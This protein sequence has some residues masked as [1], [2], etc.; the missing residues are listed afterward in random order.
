MKKTM[1]D[2]KSKNGTK[3]DLTINF[4]RS[5]CVSQVPS[6]VPIIFPLT[7]S[8]SSSISLFSIHLRAFMLIKTHRWMLIKGTLG[9]GKIDNFLSSFLLIYDLVSVLKFTLFSKEHRI[10]PIWMSEG[11]E[12]KK[13]QSVKLI[14]RF[15]WNCFQVLTMQFLWSDW[16]FF[17]FGGKFYS[18]L[19]DYKFNNGI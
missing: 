10:R 9:T 13:V 11:E 12:R 7:L 16:G 4:L 18:F 1:N 14:K 2:K 5:F 8:L 19:Y 6:I 17:F 3:S 15:Q